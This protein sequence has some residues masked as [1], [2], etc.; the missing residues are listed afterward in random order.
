MKIYPS[1]Y[2]I[3]NVDKVDMNEDIALGYLDS[4]FMEETVKVNVI[5]KYNKNSTKEMLPYN[6]INSLEVT[7]FDSNGVALTLEEQEQLFTRQESGVYMYKPKS[8]VVFEPYTFDYKVLAKKD[9]KYSS[10]RKYNIRAG[11]DNKALAEKMI[12]F[13]SD[14]YERDLCP[15]NIKFNGGSRRLESLFNSSIKD[16]DFIFIESKDGV[17]YKYAEDT[18]IPISELIEAN[19]VPWII[20]DRIPDDDDK[21]YE[22]LKELDFEMLKN[23][24]V[25]TS[26]Y[27]TNHYFK[28]P[29][30][31]TDEK[32]HH[33]FK[34][35]K[36]R[37]P[38][39]IKEITN[40]GF[41][42]YC[43]SDFMARINET[44]NLFYEIVLYIYLKAYISTQ[45][46]TEWITDEMPDYI[47]QNGRL[48]KK[49]KFTSHMEL[50]KLLG[51][52]EGDANPIEVNIEP[53]VRKNDVLVYYTGMSS[54]YLVFKKITNS[55]Y[56]DP[57]KESNQISMFTERKN[58]MFYDSF[59]YSITESISDKISYSI[60]NSE[61]TVAVRP[62]KNTDLDTRNFVSTKIVTAY[63]EESSDAQKLNLVWNINK[64]DIELVTRVI[65]EDH[66]L[67]ATIQVFKEKKDSRLHDMRQ[68]G[69]GLPDGLTN[70]DCLDI[71]NVLGRPY[72]K[73]G[74]LIITVTLPLDL[75]QR[76]D[77]MHEIIYSAITKHLVADDYLILDLKFE[78]I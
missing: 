59:I 44:H 15:T 72:R 19:V 25:N 35:H 12:Q 51:L 36:D 21:D 1:I 33:I 46:I 64:K 16:N 60:N 55:E 54:N 52:R 11:C 76:K 5:D 57:K 77:E 53:H 40:K 58:I 71:G 10:S 75:E 42:V 27:T 28:Y 6:T 56:E 2:E 63:I 37:S 39:I 70:Y 18:D 67:L 66:V 29:T 26:V 8:S 30:P 32:Y 9:M 68:R 50:H 45:K 74:S 22:N 14:S 41:V 17:R 49:E 34:Y 13:F 3:Y 20:C 61:I 65:E 69:G 78:K 38:I 23:S 31:K 43:S 62:F 73:G 24:V 4:E 7:L 47:V 48:T